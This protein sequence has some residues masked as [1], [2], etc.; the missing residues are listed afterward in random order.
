VVAKRQRH[1]ERPDA[2]LVM[3]CA[4]LVA[5]HAEQLAHARLLLDVEM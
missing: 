3:V 2:R 4:E 1:V 5:A